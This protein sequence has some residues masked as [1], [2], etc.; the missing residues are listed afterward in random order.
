MGSNQQ[1]LLVIFGLKKEYDVFPLNKN[2]KKTYGFGKKS[3]I[4]LRKINLSKID[5]VI[6]IGYCGSIDHS[7]KSG[8]IIKIRNIIDENGRK[9][10]CIN[11]SSNI[12]TKKIKKLN[13]RELDLITT[14]KVKNLKQKIKLKKRYPRISL[15]DMEA[16]HLLKELKK[17]KKNFYSIKIVYDDLSFEIPNI[18]KNFLDDDG[19]LIFNKKLLIILFKNPKLLIDLLNMGKKYI[20]CKFRLKYLVKNIFS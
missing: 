9:L 4:S 6:N 5:T 2:L 7:T 3:L 12:V 17:K 13:L 8:D 1:N 16:F 20:S 18:L 15:V 19:E 14:L 10:K 11:N